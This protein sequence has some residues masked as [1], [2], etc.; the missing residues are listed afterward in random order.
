MDFRNLALILVGM[1]L[2]ERFFCKFFCPM[3]A[4]FSLMPVLTP[5]SLRRNRPAFKNRP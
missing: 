1:A 4:I 5:F 3:G 2:E